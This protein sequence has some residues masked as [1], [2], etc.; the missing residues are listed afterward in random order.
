MDM[1]MIQYPMALRNGYCLFNYLDAD[2]SESYGDPA[3]PGIRMR[4]I[5]QPRGQNITDLFYFMTDKNNPDFEEHFRQTL[6]GEKTLWKMVWVN[7]RPLAK[8]DKRK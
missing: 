1:R 4:V 7:I 2:D 5:K 8:I 6:R 3:Y